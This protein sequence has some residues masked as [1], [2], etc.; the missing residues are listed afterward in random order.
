MAGEKNPSF[1]LGKPPHG[2]K[3]VQNCALRRAQATLM[4]WGLELPTEEEWWYLATAGVENPWWMRPESQLDPV[5]E[6]LRRLSG[7]ANLSDRT[8]LEQGI[9]GR[10]THEFEDRLRDG[11]DYPA[12][13]GSLE[14][15]EFGLYDV[16]GNV[17]EMALVA[18]GFVVMGG[19]FTSSPESSCQRT[20]GTIA[21]GVGDT[22]MGAIGVA[23]TGVRAVLRV[24][25]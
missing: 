1:E 16:L 8:A 21:A 6:F 12:P 2:A 3:P 11:F 7:F 23:D 20:Q 22:G 15:N 18:T 19:S 17:R 10:E 13:V 4:R 14:A 9:H 24:R 25:P 5:T